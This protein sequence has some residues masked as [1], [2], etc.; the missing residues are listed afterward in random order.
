MFNFLSIFRES[1]MC[2]TVGAPQW[3]QCATPWELHIVYLQPLSSIRVQ[4]CSSCSASFVCNT[5][6]Y[7]LLRC[8]HLGTEYAKMLQNLMKWQWK[9][10]V[11]IRIPNCFLLSL[12]LSRIRLHFQGP[13]T[14]PS[15]VQPSTSR[16]ISILASDPKNV[17]VFFGRLLTKKN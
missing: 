17:I 4:S 7:N 1:A 12:P 16:K 14:N 11:E 2:R 3:M 5:L 9:T 6:Q 8:A 10:G 15:E 13:C